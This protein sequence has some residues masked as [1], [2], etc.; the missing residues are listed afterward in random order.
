MAR[1]TREETEATRGRILDAARELFALH[2]FAGASL[3]AI[4]RHAKTSKSLLLHHFASKAQLW[5]A[6][7]LLDFAQYERGQLAAISDEATGA[8]FFRKSC[9]AYFRFLQKNAS[10][11]RMQLWSQAEHGTSYTTSGNATAATAAKNLVEKGVERLHDL[12]RSGETRTDLDARLVVASLLGLLRHWFV[13][14]E[15]FLANVPDR[16]AADD[17]YLHTVITLLWEGVRPRT[18]P[19]HEG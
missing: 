9:T 19:A 5:D 8:A 7:Q 4:A 2:G 18:E 17:E 6:A 1:R 11:Q 3:S 13:V 14:R 15:D 10:Y 16:D 12:Q